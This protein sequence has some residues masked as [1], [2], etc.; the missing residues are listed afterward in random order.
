MSDVLCRVCGEPWD[1]HHLKHDAPAW[2]MPLVLAGAGCESCEGEAPEN[3]NAEE[4]AEKS[5]RSFVIDSPTDGDP[6]SERPAI[7]GDAPPPWKRPDDETVWQCENCTTRIV[8]DSDEREGSAYAFRVEVT[9]DGVA[10]YRNEQTLLGYGR[11]SDFKHLESALDE[12][13]LNGSHCR[14]CAYKCRDCSRVLIEGEDFSAAPPD[15]PYHSKDY[16]CE[17]CFSTAEYESAI[18]SYSQRDLIEALGYDRNSPVGSWFDNRDTTSQ[19][20]TFDVA[21]SLGLVEIEGDRVV[22]RVPNRYK[23]L[24]DTPEN[25]RQ[26]ARILWELREAVN[27]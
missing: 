7:A 12:I 27:A 18:E 5:D 15:D 9:G 10:Q 25:R 1:V 16:L 11:E 8:R 17:E 13:S 20:I 6:L 19:T 23:H 24:I 14:L 26:R 3:V 21:D 4:I 2:V 22:Y